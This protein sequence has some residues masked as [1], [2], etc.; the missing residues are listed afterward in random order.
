M[1]A[2]GITSDF[3]KYGII[4]IWIQDCKQY[5]L[6][7]PAISEKEFTQ[8]MQTKGFVRISCTD[9][10]AIV[11][12][13]LV[14]SSSGAES[15]V[16]MFRRLLKQIGVKTKANVAEENDDSGSDGENESKKKPAPSAKSKVVAVLEART[17]VFIT[18]DEFSTNVNKARSEFTGALIINY[19]H[20][21]FACDKRTGPMCYKHRV[22]LATEVAELV[23]FHHHKASDYPLICRDDPQII[24]LNAKPGDLVEIS[25]IED[26]AAGLTTSYRYV[27]SKK[28]DMS[29]KSKAAK[30]NLSDDV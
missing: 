29:E 15:S 12:V 20:R 30:L 18:K 1:A 10:E 13:V 26:N 25:R 3:R 28:F 9:G 17:V 24:W 19:L 2:A 5:T 8:Q 7:T 6:D 4:M 27:S 11:D 14:S 23:N 16:D 22:M 21:D